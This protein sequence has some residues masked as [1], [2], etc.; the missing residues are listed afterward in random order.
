MNAIQPLQE[1][2]RSLVCV[3]VY[4]TVAIRKFVAKLDPIQLD[5]FAESLQIVF[6]KTLELAI[7]Q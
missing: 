3:A 7:L 4:Y 2:G 5:Q 1:D 6:M